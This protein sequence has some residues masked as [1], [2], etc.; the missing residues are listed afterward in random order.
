[1]WFGE[2]AHLQCYNRR[3][4]AADPWIREDWGRPLARMVDLIWQQPG[5]LGGAI[6]SGVDD[7]FHMRTET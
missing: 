2:Y 7:V 5:A 3:E 1:V 4:L 6:W